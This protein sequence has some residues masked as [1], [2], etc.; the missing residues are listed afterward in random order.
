VES[1][2][3]R[4]Q[5]VSTASLKRTS[6]ASCIRLEA[7]G[8]SSLIC[9]VRAY[10]SFSYSALACFRMGMSGSEGVNDSAKLQIKSVNFLRA[11]I[12]QNQRGIIGS[13]TAPGADFADR[14]SDSFQADNFLHLAVPDPY[15]VNSGI[16]AF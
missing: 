9:P 11:H 4:H 12:T 10:C 3:Q 8:A 13:E 2:A 6:C 16:V 7:L 15:A 14:Q 1:L 5:S